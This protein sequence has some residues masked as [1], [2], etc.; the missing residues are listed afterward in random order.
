[1]YLKNLKE[2]NQ[3]WSIVK[4]Y[5]NYGFVFIDHNISELF[6]INIPTHY[7]KKLTYR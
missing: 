2:N 5:V 1:M 7:K 6:K 4:S 3:N